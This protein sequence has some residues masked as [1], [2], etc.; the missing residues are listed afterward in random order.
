[1]YY[2]RTFNGLTLCRRVVWVL[3]GSHG[4]RHKELESS[5][6]RLCHCSLFWLLLLKLLTNH[7]LRPWEKTPLTLIKYNIIINSRTV[8]KMSECPTFHSQILEIYPASRG[9]EERHWMCA[10]NV[11]FTYLNN[12]TSPPFKAHG[13]LCGTAD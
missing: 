1:M 2:L 12:S 5:P 8:L 4:K 9:D 10:R 11:T 6:A 13:A 7:P 3:P